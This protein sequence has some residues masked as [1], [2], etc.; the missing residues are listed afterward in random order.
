M[1]QKGKN[2]KKNIINNCSVDFITSTLKNINRKI[3][4]LIIN[5]SK[6]FLFLHSRF[7]NIHKLIQSVSINASEASN[8][9]IDEENLYYLNR[10][11]DILEEMKNGYKILTEISD[12]SSDIYSEIEKKLDLLHIPL[13][14]YS[15]DIIT[16]KFLSANLK[17]DPNTLNYTDDIDKTVNI[18]SKTFPDL[19]KK[20]K[21]LSGEL[22]SSKKSLQAAK[23]SYL[24]KVEEP[25]KY[26]YDFLNKLLKK[27]DNLEQHKKLI[28]EKINQCS[29]ISS[30]IIT[31]LQYQDI[32]KQKIEHIQQT[33]D[34][35]LE[36]LSNLSNI[37]DEAHYNELKIKLFIKIRDISSLQAAQLIYA[38]KEYQKALET[39]TSKYVEQVGLAQDIFNACRKTSLVIGDPAESVK[40]SGVIAEKATTVIKLI[41]NAANSC[42][43]NINTISKKITSFS[44]LYH[45]LKTAYNSL[46]GS[47]KNIMKQLGASS[48][49]PQPVINQLKDLSEELFKAVSQIEKY[50]ED[51][52]NNISEIKKIRDKIVEIY[53][54]EKNLFESLMAEN[55]KLRNKNKN[56]ASNFSKLKKE[57]ELCDQ[58]FVSEDALDSI[59]EVKY[60]NLFEKELNHIINE[61]NNL[62]KKL[63][64]EGMFETEEEK[65]AFEN[66]KKKYTI[67]SEYVV[68]DDFSK[69][70][71]NRID[72]GLENR[73]EISGNK[74][75]DVEL[76]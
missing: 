29:E 70:L 61:L 28:N 23:N 27:H 3:N 13:N 9:F 52:L 39:I 60:Y 35:I 74:N 62:S 14:N 15:Q 7:K 31:N 76:F 56:L 44:F 41:E 58:D 33:H 32:V 5:S 2:S 43:T 24:K 18:Y 47:I 53:K 73:P 38:N 66:I 19:L 50:S 49:R 46:T 11:V 22:K 4:Y 75:D 26:L 21:V 63:N 57:G 64:V 65:I 42:E 12:D 68:H 55:Q 51:N 67:E 37:D 16:L 34:S 54:T 20:V 30:S 69:K 40:I 10:I 36:E 59:H 6:D 1:V 25:V 71:N 17:L 72:T 8:L 45:D 48:E